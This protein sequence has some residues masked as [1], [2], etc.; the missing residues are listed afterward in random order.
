MMKIKKNVVMCKCNTLSLTAIFFYRSGLL[1]RRGNSDIYDEIKVIISTINN[2][3]KIQINVT[4]ARVNAGNQIHEILE[5][6]SDVS[7][8]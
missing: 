7:F 8:F 4:K 3:L 2:K 6:R 5:E 1:H